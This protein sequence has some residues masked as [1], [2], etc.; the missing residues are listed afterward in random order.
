[1]HIEKRCPRGDT[2]FACKKIV[3]RDDAWLAYIETLL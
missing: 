2:R 1:M 3:L